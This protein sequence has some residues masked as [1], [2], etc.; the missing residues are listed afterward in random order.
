MS[1]FDKQDIQ[2][3]ADLKAGYTL[4]RTDVA[5]LNEL[6]RIALASLEAEA[7]ADVVAWSSPNEERTCDIRLRRH[8]IKAGPLYTAPPAPAN[9]EHVAWLWSHRKH[10]SEVS[11]V[12]PED[13]ER[14]EVAHWS[15]WSCQ[16]LYTAPPAP[17]VKLP[18]EFFS[19]EGIVIQLEKLMSSLAVAGI[20]YERTGNAC[21]AAMLQGADGNSPAVPEWHAEA[22]KMAELHGISFVIFRHGE[23]PKCA[24]PSKVII[25]FT[26]EGLGHGSA[27]PQQEAKP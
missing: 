22:E 2:A 17:V 13:D 10:P 3:V 15:G 27:T 16:A 11:L 12:R 4:G 23:S 21:R 20:Q 24:D 18:H 5:I 26:D 6:V 8:D 19:D 25:S 14:A 7:V 9:A 1:K